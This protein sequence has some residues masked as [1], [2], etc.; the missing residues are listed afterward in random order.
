MSDAFGPAER[1][2]ALL[3]FIKCHLTSMSRWNILRV[4]S[5]EPGPPWCVDDIARQTHTVVDVARRSLDEL[6]DEGVIE[7]YDGPAGPAYALDGAEPTSRVLARLLTEVG[8]NQ[9]LRRIIVA[10]MLQRGGAATS[11]PCGQVFGSDTESA[12]VRAMS[13]YG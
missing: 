3:A 5:E 2:P 10:R 6:T 13:R 9:G 8:R 1:D 12:P 7:R 11:P 4:L